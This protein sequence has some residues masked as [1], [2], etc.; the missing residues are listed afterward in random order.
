MKANL[1]REKPWK[2]KIPDKLDNLFSYILGSDHHVGEPNPA[3]IIKILVDIDN[4]ASNF[5]YSNFDFPNIV[6]PTMAWRRN[7]KEQFA[8][9]QKVQNRLIRLKNNKFRY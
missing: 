1:H 6:N 5:N 3:K 2:D 8:N 4:A 7:L 9:H